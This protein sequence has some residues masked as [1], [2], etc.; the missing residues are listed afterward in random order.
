M[1]AQAIVGLYNTIDD[2]YEL[3]IAMKVREMLDRYQIDRD[4]KATKR[5]K[6]AVKVVTSLINTS[7]SLGEDF[8]RRVT[9]GWLKA[10]VGAFDAK[11]ED[12]YAEID[13][14]IGLYWNSPL[15]SPQEKDY[16]EAWTKLEVPASIRSNMKMLKMSVL[17]RKYADRVLIA[18][19]Q[20]VL[21]KIANAPTEMPLIWFTWNQV[22]TMTGL[23][24]DKL[25]EHRKKFV[26][27]PAVDTDTFHRG[28]NTASIIE[29][30][31]EVDYGHLVHGKP[32]PGKFELNTINATLLGV[33]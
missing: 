22:L 1:T 21:W 20:I 23:S 33:I 10:Q 15:H 11:I 31:T 14:L 18:L 16:V 19:I 9:R 8:V 27:W 5:N 12:A 6:R 4:S 32:M 13:D 25:K 24:D 28:S 17:G 30:L 26:S 2:E 29:L 3:R 7:R